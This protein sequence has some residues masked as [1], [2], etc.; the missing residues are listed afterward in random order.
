MAALKNFDGPGGAWKCRLADTPRK[1][2]VEHAM[3]YPL[4][5]VLVDSL[6]PET[7]KKLTAQLVKVPLPIRTALYEPCKTPSHVHF[8]TSGIASIVTTMADGQTVEVATVGREGAPQ[9]IHLLAP[10]PVP[11]R[12]FMQVAGTGWRIEFKVLERLQAQEQDLHKALLAYAQYQ[13]LIS[14]QIVAC[15]RLH[16]ARSRLARWLLMLQDRTGE[17]TLKLT[18]EFLGDM[19]GSQR[20]TVNEVTST[21]EERGAIRHGRG[22][23]QILDRND[24][25]KLSC[26]CYGPTRMLLG[27]LYRMAGQPVFGEN[28]RD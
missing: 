14:G 27:A 18:Q 7:R 10:I 21:L 8:L 5:N 25:V 11:S 3:P 24:L 19:I 1:K 20:S 9:G 6:C 15:N 16:G 26:E 2:D 12:C 13:N 17:T 23:I 28:G 22:T 4:S